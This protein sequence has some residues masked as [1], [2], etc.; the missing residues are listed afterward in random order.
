M[1]NTLSTYRYQSL[2]VLMLFSF[3]L[4]AGE[5][6]NTGAPTAAPLK[7]E[8]EMKLETMQ[9]Q[10]LS[11]EL[12]ALATIQVDPRRSATIY[13]RIN[14]WIASV[15]VLPGARVKKGDTLAV[16]DGMS[17]REAGSSLR[18]AQAAYTAAAE[19]LARKKK[20]S[21]EEIIPR[22]ELT[23]AT[24]NYQ[25]A[26][27]QLDAAKAQLSLLGISGKARTV[28][29]EAPFSGTVLSADARREQTVTSADPLFTLS[30][31]SG[32][33]LTA[34]IPES[35]IR[36]LSPGSPVRI[37]SSSWPGE[38]FRGTVTSVGAALDATSKTLPVFIS[39]DNPDGRLKPEMQV[40]AFIGYT[41][42]KPV[43]SVP[44]S[45]M[46]LLEGKPTVFVARG[47]SIQPVSITPGEKGLK[48]TE[49]KTGL[50]PG[51]R[52]VI[53]GAYSLKSALLIKEV[54]GGH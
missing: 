13:P 48:R 5:T 12:R 18:Q 38:T 30:D 49:V 14:G 7:Q 2:A 23:T 31:L 28:S 26:L 6:K 53:D 19:L 9:L 46:T 42:Q 22:N 8:K 17:L 35:R 27:A 25:Q 20:L 3:P 41:T 43:L 34:S 1:I 45:A 50:N 39:V 52:V 10:L 16:L 4:W 11:G 24:M 32:V 36:Y 51:D 33:L 21:Q 44:D 15:D 29:V 40:T 54:A 37:E 47:K